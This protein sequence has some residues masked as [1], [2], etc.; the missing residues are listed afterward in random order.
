MVGLTLSATALAESSSAD[1][2]PADSVAKEAISGVTYQPTAPTAPV[3]A[4]ATSSVMT[5]PDAP[6][7]GVAEVSTTAVP[8]T[9]EAV[10][11]PTTAASTTATAQGTMPAYRVAEQKQRTQR[12]VDHA[13]RIEKWLN[14]DKPATKTVQISP[15]S[16]LAIFAEP[17]EGYN[18][19][20]E[21]PV[22]DL[23]Y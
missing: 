4:P 17:Q 19:K 22:L 13:L 14:N 15:T 2:K 21:V 11:T 20:V 1:P 5:A 6:A 3:V 18:G 12:D 7:T 9:P 8:T 16:K 10:T 23:E